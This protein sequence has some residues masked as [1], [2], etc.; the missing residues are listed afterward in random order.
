MALI[1]W[2]YLKFTYVAVNQPRSSPVPQLPYEIVVSVVGPV[3]T[4]IYP[5]L[6]GSAELKGIVYPFEY[7]ARA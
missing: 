5:G 6:G 1:D 3:G 4:D 2:I 7:G